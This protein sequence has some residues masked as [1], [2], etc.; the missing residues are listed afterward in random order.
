MKG[1][2]GIKP[3]TFGEEPNRRKK[4]KSKKQE[5]KWAETVDGKT[6]PASGAT[7][8]S[9]GDVKEKL[10]NTKGMFTKF[11]WDNKYTEAKSFRIQ[12]EDWER[13][14][15]DAYYAGGYLPGMEVEII[16]P[17]LKKPVSLVVIEKDDFLILR[18]MVNHLIE[19]MENNE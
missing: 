7:W 13:L 11:L 15:K 16:N 2:S 10:K 14:R 12:A 17:S 8:H 4:K 18:D 6:Q 19:R 9:K 5:N 3:F 1:G